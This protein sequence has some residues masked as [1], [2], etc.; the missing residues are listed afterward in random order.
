MTHYNL[1]LTSFSLSTNYLQQT[2]NVT[3]Y[4]RRSGKHYY[5]SIIIS[6][7]FLQRNKF[8]SPG[9]SLR[10]VFLNSEWLFLADTQPDVS[11]SDIVHSSQLTLADLRKDITC[12]YESQ[13][14]FRQ[15]EKYNTTYYIIGGAIFCH[16]SEIVVWLYTP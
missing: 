1:P 3:F 8:S 4:G 11:I 12:T 5:L 14:K 10:F 15:T 16:I 9:V 6:S 13:P 7:S 2:M